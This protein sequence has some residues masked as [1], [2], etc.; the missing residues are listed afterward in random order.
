MGG[1]EGLGFRHV[2]FSV[3]W[4][5][6]NHTAAFCALKAKPNNLFVQRAPPMLL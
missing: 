6:V 4:L 2:F 1:E 5:A 3:V